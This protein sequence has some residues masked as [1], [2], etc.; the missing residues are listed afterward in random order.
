SPLYPLSLHDALPIFRHYD[1]ALLG[2]ERAFLRKAAFLRSIGRDFLS[3]MG[4]G[5]HGR[6]WA[7]AGVVPRTVSGVSASACSVA[8]GLAVAEDRK[9][10]RLNS[11]HDQI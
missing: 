6:R 8:T 7:G 10:T 9:S 11:S 2:D 4:R 1:V 3:F 5:P